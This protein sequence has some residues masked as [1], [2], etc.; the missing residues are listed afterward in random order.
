VA[1]AR[2]QKVNGS[3]VS[4][5][6]IAAT[7]GSTTTAGNLL[8]AV[9]GM[10]ATSGETITPPAGWTLAAGG[11][12][13]NTS[14][15]PHLLVSIYYIENAAAR[16]GSESFSLSGTGVGGG[17][18]ELLEYSGMGVT[19]GPVDKTTGNTG[20]SSSP[21]SGTTASTTTASEV[22]IAGFSTGSGITSFSS[23][24]NSFAILDQTTFGTGL[25]GGALESIV[26]STGAASTGV[27]SANAGWAGAIATFAAAGAAS[28][29]TS[30]PAVVRS[31]MG[32]PPIP[33]KPWSQLAF[34]SREV[35][36]NA[37]NAAVLPPHFPI[38]HYRG[39]L[40]LMP[41][42]QDGELG[43][44]TDT[45]VWYG[46]YGGV[47]YPVVPTLQSAANSLK[48]N[49]TGSTAN[50]AD[51]TVAQVWAML[52]LTTGQFAGYLYG[53]GLIYSSSSVIFVNTGNCR[54]KADAAFVSLTSKQTVTISTAASIS[55][56]DRRTLTG[57]LATNSGGGTPKRVDGT[58][59]AFLTEFGIKAGTG[60]ITTVGTAGS[61]GTGLMSPLGSPQV[62]VNDLVG[63]AANGYSRVTAIASD[64]TFTLS[65][66]IPGGDLTASA[67]NVIEQPTIT[68]G[69]QAV[70]F[71]DTINSNTLLFLTSNSTGGTLTGQTGRTGDAPA[72][73]APTGFFYYYVW[74][75]SGGSGT[76]C[77]VSTQRTTPFG[78]TGYTTSVRRIGVI[79]LDSSGAIVPVT[80]ERY[81]ARARYT[82]QI[83]RTGASPELA[84]VNSNPG[85]LTWNPL[86]VSAAPPTADAL[87]I[88]GLD[89]A[90]T[91]CDTR[92]RNTGTSATSRPHTQG[93]QNQNT[94][95]VPCDGAQAIDYSTAV[96]GTVTL[97]LGGFWESV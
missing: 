31:S 16:S 55:G 10:S 18:I 57:T 59:T 17:W 7:W 26:S 60:T 93:G 19:A 15:S 77:Y 79:E 35:L 33:G 27:T 2:V 75:A 64:S 21:S 70:N 80:H 72:T 82:F 13:D 37:S 90:S 38:Q 28:G 56:N 22:W 34:P 50:A 83:A 41:T 58:S 23:P 36:G 8:V 89:S 42:L 25:R 87:I 4:T 39:T 40:A 94:Y 43:F 68:V 47:N 12:G 3:S 32:G 51:L 62:A 96:S 24:T 97:Y 11:T 54:D 53:L 78:V 76:G 88:T 6:P 5:G 71:V 74:L 1:I 92:P 14:S 65:A 44:A 30:S 81:G 84:I 95:D 20:S 45:L 86:V 67:F 85:N 91:H 63:T 49:N 69:S 66:S 29:S 52:N 46:G 9:V 73:S 61:G 48:G